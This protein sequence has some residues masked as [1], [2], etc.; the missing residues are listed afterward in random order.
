MQLT[1]FAVNFRTRQGD[2]PVADFIDSLPPWAQ[3]VVDRQI[4]RLNEFGPMIPSPHTHQVKGKLRELRC[5]SGKLKIRVLYHEA[6]SHL[7]LLLHIFV[8]KTPRIPPADIALA[9]SRWVDFK[10]RMDAEPRVPP[11]P[12]GSDA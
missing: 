7:I 11:R 6:E 4:D 1:W 8:K 10:A 9:E 2:E 5:Y 12:I 3:Q